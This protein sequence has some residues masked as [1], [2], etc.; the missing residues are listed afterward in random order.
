MAKNPLEERPCF[1]Y[2]INLPGNYAL[3]FTMNLS[4]DLKLAFL[5]TARKARM[6]RKAD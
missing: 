6:T 3:N 2:R 5:A 4:H 1:Q